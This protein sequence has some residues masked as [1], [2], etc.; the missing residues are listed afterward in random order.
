MQ[1]F[2][3]LYYLMKI[4]EKSHNFVHFQ[5][6]DFWVL[7]TETQTEQGS[8]NLNKNKCGVII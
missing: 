2:I 7:R 3:V 6:L 8:C 1:F 4:R 5:H